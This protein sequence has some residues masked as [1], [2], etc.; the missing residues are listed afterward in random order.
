MTPANLSP[1]A[2]L[3]SAVRAAKAFNMTGRPI[4]L[5]LVANAE[6]LLKQ[7]KPDKRQVKRMAENLRRAIPNK[8]KAS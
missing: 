2:A 3:E 1:I 6:D 4:L 7:D 5:G 8:M